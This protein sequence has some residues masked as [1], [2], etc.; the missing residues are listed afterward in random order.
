MF[1]FELNHLHIQILFVENFKHYCNLHQ[2]I[3]FYLQDGKIQS[4]SNEDRERLCSSWLF[5]KCF[6]LDF[7][8]CFFIEEKIFSNLKRPFFL[9]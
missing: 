3:S 9:L 6:R 2:N 8:S 1:D 7:G 5:L 4:F